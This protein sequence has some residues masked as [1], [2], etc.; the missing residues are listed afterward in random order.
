M[1]WVKY[2]KT[3][4]LSISIAR[5]CSIERHALIDFPFAQQDH[6]LNGTGIMLQMLVFKNSL[7]MDKSCK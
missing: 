1:C 7:A 5:Y 2:S 3:V 4:L 6:K